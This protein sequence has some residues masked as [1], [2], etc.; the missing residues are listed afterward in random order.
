MFVGECVLGSVCVCVC[1]CVSVCVGVCG[2]AS[3]VCVCVSVW[4]G[5]GVFGSWGLVEHCVLCVSMINAE[6]LLY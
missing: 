6:E 5:G 2:L 1:V 3:G 4:V